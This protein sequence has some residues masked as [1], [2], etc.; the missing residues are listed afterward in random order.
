MQIERLCPQNLSA[1]LNYLH[2]A[3]AEEPAMMTIDAINEP[4]L[5][6]RVENPSQND[7]ASLL[8]ILD[9]A[10]VGRIEYHFYRCMQDGYRMAYVS[11]VYVAKQHRRKGIAQALFAAFERECAA[12]DVDE[13]FLL[14][15]N[16]PAATRF[17][18]SFA[19]ANS[20]KEMVLR[21]GIQ[22]E[23]LV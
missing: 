11:W 13:Y 4:E 23:K 1:Y 12:Q 19:E 5:V 18:Q 20:T 15:A 7:T 21:K 2:A 3:L 14:Q 6:S 17:Y 8:A 22:K 10:V 9:G 16:N